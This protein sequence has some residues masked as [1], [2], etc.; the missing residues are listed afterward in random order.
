[1]AS[2]VKAAAG[3]PPLWE[4]AAP[5]ALFEARFPAI[6]TG[7]NDYL[8]EPSPDGQRFLVSVTLG[9]A[10]EAPLTVVVNWLAGVKK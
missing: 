9:E 6:P 3:P 8:Y 2:A 7:F 10:V 5:Q 1:M 4:S